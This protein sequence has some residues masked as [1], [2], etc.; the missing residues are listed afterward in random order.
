MEGVGVSQRAI[1]AIGDLLLLAG[2]VC[3]VR[4]PIRA[5]VAAEDSVL[6]VASA[7]RGQK[8][9]HAPNNERSLRILVAVS[10]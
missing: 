5:V 6:S 7:G 9:V 3:V 4:A 2:T 10:A 1:G 8:R